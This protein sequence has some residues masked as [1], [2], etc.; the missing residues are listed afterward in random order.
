MKKK[1]DGHSIV[2]SDSIIHGRRHGH[3][4]KSG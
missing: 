3:N 1:G 4:S 2:S